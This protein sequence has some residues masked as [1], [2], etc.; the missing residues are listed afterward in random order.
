MRLWHSSQR[1]RGPLQQFQQRGQSPGPIGG[2]VARW[3]RG[4]W[5]SEER[6][7]RDHGRAASSYQRVS[8][9]NARKQESCCEDVLA[10]WHDVG[11][12]RVALRSP[13]LTPVF[14]A[15]PPLAL[16][17]R[18]H[19]HRPTHLITVELKVLSP[20]FSLIVNRRHRRRRTHGVIT[21]PC[22]GGLP[23][24]P[25]GLTPRQ[26]SECVSRAFGA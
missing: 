16:A 22:V 19:I 23:S 21:R 9:F 17:Q 2:T 15:T 3:T 7:L 26:G 24:G 25:L 12:V 4:P 18:S 5:V 8:E 20:L 6:P 13:R 14:C 10:A 1:A 11:V